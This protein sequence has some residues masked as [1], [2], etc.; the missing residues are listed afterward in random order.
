MDEVEGGE[1]KGVGFDNWLEGGGR[2]ECLGW[3]SGIEYIDV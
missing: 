2:P 1:E 3:L